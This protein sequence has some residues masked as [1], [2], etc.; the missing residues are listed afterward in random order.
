MTNSCV[1][2]TRACL[3]IGFSAICAAQ[4]T[5]QRPLFWH[6]EVVPPDDRGRVLKLLEAGIRGPRFDKPLS[7]AFAQADPERSLLIHDCTIGCK[8]SWCDNPS[9]SFK[10]VF[11]RAGAISSLMPNQTA[12]QWSSSA[13]QVIPGYKDV[14]GHAWNGQ[15]PDDAPF[16]LLAVVNRMDLATWDST[17]RKWQNA[18][19]RFVYGTSLTSPSSGPANITLILF[20]LPDLSWGDFQ[21]LAGTW[22]ALAPS[23]TPDTQ[24]YTSLSTLVASQLSETITFARLRT[25]M[26]LVASDWTL[27][28]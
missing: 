4:N 21:T 8:P 3:L 13:S 10:T 17:I 18:E 20:V 15:Q 24:F 12:Q 22:Q 2:R 27:V 19:L 14:I 1:L 26:N 23:T 7:A 16:V 28:Q 5:A 6:R 25:N 11:A 9:F